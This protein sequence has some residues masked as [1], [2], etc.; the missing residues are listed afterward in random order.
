MDVPLTNYVTKLNKL[1][2]KDQCMYINKKLLSMEPDDISYHT[3]FKKLQMMVIDLPGIFNDFIKNI[4]I[5][6]IVTYNYSFNSCMFDDYLFHE[7]KAH[8]SIFYKR[9]KKDEYLVNIPVKGSLKD[10]TTII[11]II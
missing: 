9:L 2:Y 5:G 11:K 1:S 7:I 4:S 3:F 10:I 6:D 8:I